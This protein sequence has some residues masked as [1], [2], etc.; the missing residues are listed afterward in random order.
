MQEIGKEAIAACHA[1]CFLASFS[2]LPR[3]SCGGSC[4]PILPGECLTNPGSRGAP[5]CCNCSSHYLWSPGFL[6]S[7]R[8]GS[9]PGNKHSSGSTF[10][11]WTGGGEAGL[12]WQTDC[13]ESQKR[14]KAFQRKQVAFILFNV[15]SRVG[16]ELFSYELYLDSRCS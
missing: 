10:A 4:Y 13:K 16:S 3:L 6:W 15:L 9:E 2:C 8:Q 1:S 7:R 5:S 12:R 11:N 14:M